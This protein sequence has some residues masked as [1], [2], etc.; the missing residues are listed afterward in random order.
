[1]CGRGRCKIAMESMAISTDVSEGNFS[2]MNKFVGA[3]NMSPGMYF[4][5]KYIDRNGTHHLRAMLWGL[6]PGFTPA[7]AAPDHFKMFNARSE[8]IFQKASFSKLI[9]THRG[10]VYMNGY[11]E[12][13]KEAGTK[14]PFYIFRSSTEL[15]KMACLFDT[16]A[17]VGGEVLHTFSIV[18]CNSNKAIEWLHDRQPLFLTNSAIE[19]V[20]LNPTST[21]GDIEKVLTKGIVPLDIESHAVTTKMSSITYQE[22]DCCIAIPKERKVDSFFK[23]REHGDDGDIYNTDSNAVASS[24]SPAKRKKNEAPADGNKISSY[25]ATTRDPA[26]R[27]VTSTYIHFIAVLK[28]VSCSGRS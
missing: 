12:W 17:P 2:Q 10:I 25:F 26:N 21:R 23:K 15:L 6:I 27:Y 11:Y 18:T 5:V 4:P 1:M 9:M 19:S 24:P 20:W 7:Y 14:Q 13:K 28:P 22:E 16:W 3:E 8:T